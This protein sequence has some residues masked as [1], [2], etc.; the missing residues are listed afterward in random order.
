MDRII[1]MEIF[2][3]LKWIVIGSILFGVNCAYGAK[4]KCE[5]SLTKSEQDEPLSKKAEQLLQQILSVQLAPLKIKPRKY[6]QLIKK[7]VRITKD[8][9]V[10]SFAI[11]ASFIHMVTHHNLTD[12]QITQLMKF[13][14]IEDQRYIVNQILRQAYNLEDMTIAQNRTEDRMS[15]VRQLERRLDP[16]LMGDEYNNIADEYMA[17]GERYVQLAEAG[18]DQVEQYLEN[19]EKYRK[20]GEDYLVRADYRPSELFRKPVHER[21]KFIA[22]VSQLRDKGMEML[23]KSHRE[24]LK[25]QEVAQEVSERSSEMIRLSSELFERAEEMSNK[26]QEMYDRA[27]KKKG[28]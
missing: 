4:Q 15:L 7:F 17:E 2:K 16:S 9:G 28:R 25:A 3:N 21:R 13:V 20:D 19:S 14:A 12:N 5:E 27:K 10:I 18:A 22:E 26:A 6:I 23:G 11:R 8:E 1:L 24:A